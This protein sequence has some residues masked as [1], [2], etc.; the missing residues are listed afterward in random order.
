[1]KIIKANLIKK[2]LWVLVIVW[3]SGIFLNG[4][5]GIAE[6]THAQTLTNAISAGSVWSITN[7]TTTSNSSI[8]TM[9]LWQI[10]DMV[11][12]IIYLLLWPLLVLAGLALDNTLVYASIFHLDAPL[13][14]FWNM[15]KNFANFTLW[16]MVLFAIIKSI[17]TN[18]DTWSIKDEKSPLGIIKITLIAWILIQASWFIVA[19]LIDI[20]TIATYAVW[21]L[22]L[23]VLKNTELGTQKILSVNSAIDFNK[24][25][26]LSAKGE[27]FK[28]WYSTTYK[29]KTITISPC[30]IANGYSGATQKSYIIGRQ[31]GDPEY[32]NTEKLKPDYIWYNVCV[33]N[34]TQLVLWEEDNLMTSIQKDQPLWPPEPWASATDYRTKDGY[35]HY[36]DILVAT[37]WRV[38][39]PY[40][41]QYA[42]NIGS[43]KWEIGFVQW[44][45]FFEETTSMT[46]SDLITKSKGFVWSLV[47]MYSSLLNFAQLTDTNV[48]TIGETSWVFLIKS[49]VAIALFFP[50]L[51]LA[52]VLIARIWVLRLYIVASPFIIIKASFKNFIKMDKLDEYLDIKN[53]MGLIFAPVVTVAALSISLIFMTALVNGFTSSSSHEEVSEAM[54]IQSIQAIQPGND[55]ISVHNVTQLEFSK[56]PRGEW[57]DRF[58]WLMVNFFAIWLMRMIFFAAI[59]ANAIGKKVWQWIQDFWQ[60]VFQSLPILPIPG[61]DGKRVGIGSAASVLTKVPDNYIT[62]IQN[63]QKQQVRDWIDQSEGKNISFDDETTSKLLNNLKDK[64]W[65]AALEA[66]WIK[67]PDRDDQLINVGTAGNIDRMYNAMKDLKDETVKNTIIAN[68]V[69]LFGE[70]WYTKETAKRTET[71]IKKTIT[72]GITEKSWEEDITNINTLLTQPDNQ[73]TLTKYFENTVPTT[74]TYKETFWTKTLTIT[75]T[76][77]GKPQKY[78]AKLA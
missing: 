37:S 68:A 45:K 70:N 57:L 42:V 5:V 71:D 40:V 52:V 72:M 3:C 4:H 64:K 23:S 48:T 38:N 19:A 9:S 12:K 24:F 39:K 49:L 32:N 46:I 22:P 21:G 69:P 44:N 56:L 7:T 11:L 10:L 50:L 29:D 66:T 30:R 55:A 25:D 63:D 8:N 58:S 20:S 2:A 17:L 53:V 34:G 33:I 51:A 36:L 73:N 18:G 74:D 54:G 77:D 43:W 26:V 62:N 75:K 35:K 15:M 6:Q 27:G 28:V 1:M 31:F 60:N 76:N 78:I 16:F 13:W 41:Q 65:R 14:K 59:K 47:T 67:A 61:Q